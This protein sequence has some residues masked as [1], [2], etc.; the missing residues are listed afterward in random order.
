MSKDI[1]KILDTQ[2]KKDF[3][4][5]FFLFNL[6]KS[7]A[8]KWQEMR[9][10]HCWAEWGQRQ[11][12][13][14]EDRFVQTWQRDLLTPV[15]RQQTLRLFVSS[16]GLVFVLTADKPLQAFSR[17]ATG[18]SKVITPWLLGSAKCPN[19]PNQ[20]AWELRGVSNRHRSGNVLNNVL[21]TVQNKRCTRFP[22]LR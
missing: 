6:I 10:T 17:T 4:F 8:N 9:Q 15:A 21:A 18:S 7:W 2:W 1:S 5:G 3:S 19:G 20:W 16:A 11:H 22:W 14:V 13:K 12:M